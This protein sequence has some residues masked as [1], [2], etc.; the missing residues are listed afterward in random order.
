MRGHTSSQDCH[1]DSRREL[2]CGGHQTSFLEAQFV[3]H[4]P[5]AL[6]GWLLKV[7]SPH[8]ELPSP[9]DSFRSNV[10]FSILQ[11]LDC[12]KENMLKE[13]EPNDSLKNRNIIN[14]KVQRKTL[15]IR[16][17]NPCSASAARKVPPQF[18]PLPAKSGDR[19]EA[20]PQ[21]TSLTR[22]Q[23]GKPNQW[24]LVCEGGL[25][26]QQPLPAHTHS[27]HSFSF[28]YWIRHIGTRK[29]CPQVPC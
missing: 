15:K 22:A 1:Q 23:E 25:D 27:L 9:P 29:R 28:S 4:Q 16:R 24:L 20:G 8:S 7:S 3:L 12:S 19:D 17:S 21:S 13:K 26:S 14:A 18:L 5:A 6:G 10:T 2:T 11:K